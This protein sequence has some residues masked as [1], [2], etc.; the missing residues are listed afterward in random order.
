MIDIRAERWLG[1][2]WRDGRWW[3]V[4]ADG[5]RVSHAEGDRWVPGWPRRASRGRTALAVLL[6]LLPV[7]AFGHGVVTGQLCV[8]PECGIGEGIAIQDPPRSDRLPVV[9]AA[10][11][12]RQPVDELR[13]A[14]QPT[15]AG[16]AGREVWRLVRQPGT[17]VVTQFPLDRPVPGYREARGRP[18]EVLTE[19][20]RA[21]LDDPPA[22]YTVTITY[23]GG[24]SDSTQLGFARSTSGLRLDTWGEPTLEQFAQDASST[25]LCLPWFEDAARTLPPSLLGPL[26]AGLGLAVRAARRSRFTHALVGEA[27]RTAGADRG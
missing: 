7:L 21:R 3:M 25:S 16:P 5:V 19:A 15:P 26:L 4:R 6:L 8:V 18:L 10:P 11:C 27:V 17:G 24:L 2:V 14:E 1:P 9:Y 13:V 12:S 20:Y 22:L 23:S